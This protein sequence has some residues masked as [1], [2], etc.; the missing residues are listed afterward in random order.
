MIRRRIIIRLEGFFIRLRRRFVCLARWRRRLGWGWERRRDRRGWR[1][2]L[3]REGLRTFTRL[4][5][6]LSIWC[7]R[8]GL[9]A[10]RLKVDLRWILRI[11]L[12]AGDDY[13]RLN[14]L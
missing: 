11:M 1:R 10:E 5:R 3:G 9:R 12:R 14:S 8:R 13:L 7:L 2:W 6:H 4:R